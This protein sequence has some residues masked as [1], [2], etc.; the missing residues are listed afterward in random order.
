MTEL[1]ELKALWIEHDRKLEA[2]LRLNRRLVDEVARSHMRA[3]FGRARWGMVFELVTG[4]V[5]PLWLAVFT[6]KHLAEPRFAVA[7]AALL[8]GAVA[9]LVSTIRQLALTDLDHAAA[10]TQTQRQVQVLRRLRR[11]SVRWTLLLS[12]LAWPALV[13]VAMKGFL[14]LDAWKLLGA[15]WLWSNVAFGIA[16]PVIAVWA[17]RRFGARWRASRFGAW[18][19]DQLSGSSLARAERALESLAAFESDSVLE[20][21]RE[22]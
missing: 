21:E 22:L 15:P 6:W 3:A 12:P 7:G 4:I 18:F 14:G 1:D 2:S 20:S 9:L 10:I 17:A 8:V 13:I 5:P 16:V 11:S 19:A